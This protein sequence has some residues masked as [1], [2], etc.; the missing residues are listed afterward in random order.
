MAFIP[1]GVKDTLCKESENKDKV[2][3]NFKKL[4][5]S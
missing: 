3:H 4:Y 5:R 1:E 2:I